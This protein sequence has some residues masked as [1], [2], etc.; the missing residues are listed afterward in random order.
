MRELN[1]LPTALGDVERDRQCTLELP[2][3]VANSAHAV[4]HPNH[5]SAFADTAFLD[6]KI[7]T[8]VD[9]PMEL[10][11]IARQ[12]LRVGN[13]LH[14]HLK[15]FRLRIAHN[16]AVPGVRE[17]ETP[18]QVRACHTDRGL[19]GDG[20]ETLVAFPKRLFGPLARRNVGYHDHEADH[21]SERTSM[22]GIDGVYPAPSRPQ[23]VD[24]YFPVDRFAGK[25]RLDMGA[26]GRPGLFTQ[27]L[28]NR[29]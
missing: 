12:I 3:S 6:D 11:K 25:C 20:T 4:V 17:G 13:V 21:L 15:K 7:P 16:F 2:I 9:E 28:S 1:F 14:A 8:T 27:N 29:L 22:R 26:H 23:I 10:F 5:A 24:F 18:V 19:V